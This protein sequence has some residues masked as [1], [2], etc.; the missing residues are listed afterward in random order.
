MR[1][2]CIAGIHEARH[3]DSLRVVLVP[4]S[5]HVYVHR[6]EPSESVI[7]LAGDDQSHTLFDRNL[8]AYQTDGFHR[9]GSPSPIYCEAFLTMTFPLLVHFIVE[10][11]C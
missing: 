2:A 6:S 10:S 8:L 5:L 11:F 4:F 7:S 3:I 1:P 9:Q